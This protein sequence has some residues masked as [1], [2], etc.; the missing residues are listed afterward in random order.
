MAEFVGIGDLHFPD[1]GGI[2][3]LAK[4]LDNPSEFIRQEVEKVLAW[5]TKKGVTNIIFYGDISENPR[6]SYEGHLALISIFQTHP[7]LRFFVILGNH[8]K[9]GP[10]SAD[11]HSLEV[12]CRLN[13]PNVTFIT[14][15]TTLTI[16]KARVHFM[17]WPCSTF[18]KK[19]LNVAHI[20]VKGSKSDSGRV[21]DSEELTK[22]S[23]VACI[24]HLHTAHKV[25]NAYY[26]GTIYQTNFGEG[27][28][29]YFHHIRFRSVDDY[30]IEYI[31][32]KPQYRLYTVIVHSKSDL[33]SLSTDPNDLIKL[34]IE[35]G[36]DIEPSD[37]DQ[38]SNIVIVKAY[39][40]KA[41]LES[42][43]VEDLTSVQELEIRSTDFFNKWL[44]VQDIQPDL[45]KKVTKL[46]KSILGA[47]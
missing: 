40:S 16:D 35:D 19:A 36:A 15:E 12:L 14:E 23:A 22:T 5:A 24:G 41:E 20:E 47:T 27:V 45:K 11:G 17:P 37:Y 13:F 8:D 7:D 44:S 2:G 43:I 46:R 28:K 3:G 29:K 18:D 4:Y 32:H 39:R 31:P 25:K 42:I 6:M 30:E 1:A 9:L 38:R 21:F 10:N 34:V 26:S 33:K